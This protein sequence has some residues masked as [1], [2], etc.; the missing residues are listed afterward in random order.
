MIGTEKPLTQPKSLASLKKQPSKIGIVI[1]AMVTL[2]LYSFGINELSKT[3]AG[4]V[5]AAV[6]EAVQDYQ[7]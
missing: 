1:L 4:I 3:V 5:E 6:Q 2:F 7:F